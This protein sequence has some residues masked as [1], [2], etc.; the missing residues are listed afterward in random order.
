MQQDRV[1]FLLLSFLNSNLVCE[2]KN[3]VPCFVSVI[4]IHVRIAIFQIPLSKLGGPKG[5]II[6]L[7]VLKNIY[8]WYGST[9]I[10]HLYAVCNVFFR[11]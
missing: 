7:A 11:L 8:L 2:K 10:K 5:N 9:A 3:H 1:L 6:L 4:V